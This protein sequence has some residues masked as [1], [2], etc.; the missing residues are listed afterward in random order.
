MKKPKKKY[1]DKCDD[2]VLY[3]YCVDCKSCE[4]HCKCLGEE[5][6]GD[7]LPLNEPLDFSRSIG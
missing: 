5:L 6:D 1:C 4:E 7:G 2:W 3:L